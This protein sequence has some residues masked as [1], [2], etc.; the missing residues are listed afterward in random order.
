MGPSP[1]DSRAVSWRVSA[2]ARVPSR[3]AEDQLGVRVHL[4]DVGDVRRVGR[5]RDLG[6]F[7]GGPEFPGSRAGWRGHR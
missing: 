3:L 4:G 1:L 6:N 5:L 2:E 7:R